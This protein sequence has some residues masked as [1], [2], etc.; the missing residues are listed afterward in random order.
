MSLLENFSLSKPYRFCI[1]LSSVIL[2]SSFIAQP[3]DIDV[4]H[5][6]KACFSLIKWGVVFW[7]L[8]NIYYDYLRTLKSKGH[9]RHDY[10]QYQ[11]YH[12]IINAGLNGIYLVIALL[13]IGNNF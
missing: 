12:T 13:I 2:V 8:E 5:L 1:Y 4:N 7:I 11:S 9:R 6:R 3:L 10:E